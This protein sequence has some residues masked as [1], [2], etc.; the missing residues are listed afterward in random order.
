MIRTIMKQKFKQKTNVPNVICFGYILV[1]NIK[2]EN[3][4]IHKCLFVWLYSFLH[5][6][7]MVSKKIQPQNH[8]LLF[9]HHKFT[10][11]VPMPLPLLK[12]QKVKRARKC[13]V[14][15][16]SKPTWTGQPARGHGMVL[17]IFKQKLACQ[18][19]LVP[20]NP[21]GLSPSVYQSNPPEVQHWTT[22]DPIQF[23]F[24]FPF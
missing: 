14:I 16:P 17:P 1:P 22:F 18:G 8:C 3:T 13:H 4:I 10:V 7:N 6:I 5:L 9:K 19:G 12:F 2:N 23:N 24:S 20:S 21:Y 11:L 15:P